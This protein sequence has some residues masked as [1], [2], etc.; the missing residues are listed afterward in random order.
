MTT[1][2]TSKHSDIP[3]TTI[4]P[5]FYL[6]YQSFG[7]FFASAPTEAKALKCLKAA[8]MLEKLLKMLS[9]TSL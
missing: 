3:S 7:R 9:K 5:R 2:Y 8:F 4:K 6:T 1:L